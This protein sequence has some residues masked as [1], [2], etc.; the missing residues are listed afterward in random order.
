MYVYHLFCLHS[1]A[2]PPMFVASQ[3]DHTG[4]GCRPARQAEEEAQSGLEVDIEGA[5]E[6]VAALEGAPQ[7]IALVLFP[8]PF[9]T[10]L[11]LPRTA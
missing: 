7:P 2:L 8:Y 4:T 9:F 11:P 1:A 10:A 5:E 6:A 3:V